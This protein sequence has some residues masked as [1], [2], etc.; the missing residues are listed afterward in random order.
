MEN[1]L[2]FVRI[3]DRLIH[4]QVVAAWLHAYA[5]VKDIMIVDDK[6]SEDPFMQDMFELLV[7]TGIKIKIYN[8]DDAV[9][10]LKAGL[11]E[12]T[13]MIV[14]FPLTIKRLVDAGIDISYLNIGG[15]GMTGDR[16]SFHKNISVSEQEKEIFRELI[17]K[18]MHI[19]IQIIPAYNKVDVAQLIK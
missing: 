4:G 1:N 12:K 11:T 5:D 3:D 8:V 17:A 9:K 6:T 16:K 14:K 13:M 18:G 10:T 19:D 15:M 2:E 7:P